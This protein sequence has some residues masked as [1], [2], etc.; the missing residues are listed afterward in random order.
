[1]SGSALDEIPILVTMPYVALIKEA[2][3]AI[4]KNDVTLHV[5]LTPENIEL[6]ANQVLLQ[7]VIVNL[8]GNAIHA[9]EGRKIRN[10]SINGFESGEKAIIEVEDSGP[11]ISQEHLSMIFDPFYT[12]KRSGQGLGLGLTI[13][14]RILKEM[15]GDI[16]AETSPEGAL[17]IISLTLYTGRNEKK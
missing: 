17:F 9:V 7:Q 16:R 5:Q 6:L 14:E 4:R 11:G 8:L 15:A 12:T 13:S 2:A 1:M 10:I 3:I